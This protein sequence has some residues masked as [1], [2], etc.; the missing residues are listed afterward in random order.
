MDCT[1][2]CSRHSDPR[3]FNIPV[4]VRE[5][6]DTSGIRTQIRV[7]VKGFASAHDDMLSWHKPSRKLPSTSCSHEMCWPPIW[8]NPFN[9]TYIPST[10]VQDTICSRS[11]LIL[12]C[13]WLRSSHA[14]CHTCCHACCHTCY[15]PRSRLT[16]FLCPR[17]LSS[18]F[19]K[20]CLLACEYSSGQKHEHW[21]LL[22]SPPITP[23]CT[24]TT[25]KTVL[26]HRDKPTVDRVDNSET[27]MTQHHIDVQ[28][29]C[30]NDFSDSKRHDDGWTLV[31]NKRSRKS[32]ANGHF[33][34]RQDHHLWTTKDKNMKHRLIFY[35]VSDWLRHPITLV[36]T[37][38]DS[39]CVPR[40]DDWCQD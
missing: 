28:C 4:Q 5:I 27:A 37:N 20:T 3:L 14:C 25:G 29:K 16:S 38:P 30:S 13:E 21:S 35:L 39:L 6:N 7:R 34:I 24:T 18:N 33:T 12:Q 36:T 17:M 23:L 22:P 1:W 31:S 19:L 9:P 2:I 8:M 11:Y 10:P 15:Q 32:Q 26:E 40:V